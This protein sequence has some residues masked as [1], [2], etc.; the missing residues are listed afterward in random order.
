MEDILFTKGEAIYDSIYIKESK[1]LILS[2]ETFIGIWNINSLLQ[3]PIQIIK[4]KSHNLLNFNEN[5]FISY[6]IKIFQSI[7]K[8]II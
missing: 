2:F 4:N 1:L 3:K 6:D 5:V 8:Q 7:K